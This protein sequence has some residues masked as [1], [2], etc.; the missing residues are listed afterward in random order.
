MK[1][2]DKFMIPAL[3]LFSCLAGTFE[4]ARVQPESFYKGKTIRIIVGAMAGGFYDRWA[5]LLSRSM[6][7]YIPGN[8]DILVQNMPG[9]EA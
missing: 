5:R 4:S 1:R 6:P 2:L 3:T 9:A 8:P 7:K